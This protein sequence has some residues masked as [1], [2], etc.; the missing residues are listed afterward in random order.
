MTSPVTARPYADS[1][2]AYAQPQQQVAL[3]RHYDASG[4]LLY[5]GITNSPPLRWAQ[6]L[7]RTV[8]ARFVTA[9]T[10]AWYP[11][12]SAA[13]ASERAAI[14]RE[15]PLFNVARP[16]GGGGYTEHQLRYLRTGVSGLFRRVRCQS[17]PNEFCIAC[18]PDADAWLA[19]QR[20]AQ[21][22]GGAA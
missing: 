11:D 21:L 1:V 16:G 2:V 3:Y 5:I 13:A 10:L 17:F 20:G 18:G 8:W 19:A 9:S 12:R 14:R 22:T 7:E 6:H 4:E 15:R